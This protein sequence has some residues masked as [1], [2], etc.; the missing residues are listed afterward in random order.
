MTRPKTSI[1]DLSP[2][3]LT[4]IFLLCLPEDP[5]A[6]VSEPQPDL[7][8]APVLL[9]H[10][11]SSWRA[12]AFKIPRLW[13]QLRICLNFE[14]DKDA[15]TLFTR[16]PAALARQIEF[17]EW[18]V[19]KQHSV[20]PYL[21]IEVKH[22]PP[23]DRVDK[24]GKALPPPKE[25]VEFSPIKEKHLS[26]LL[27]YISSAQYLCVDD[28][29][30]TLM[31]EGRDRNEDDLP[32]TFPNLHTLWTEY[33]ETE[34]YE[35][36]QTAIATIHRGLFYL[37]FLNPI[38]EQNP[39]TLRRLYL[40]HAGLTQL[41]PN[42]FASWTVLTHIYLNIDHVYLTTWYA[43][44]RSLPLLTY[45]NFH[46]TNDILIGAFIGPPSETIL[47]RLISLLINVNT[48]KD[49]TLEMRNPVVSLLQNVRMPILKE[50]SLHM[51]R[52]SRW[53]SRHLIT[54]LYPI[55]WLTPQLTI[56]SL[57]HVVLPNTNPGISGANIEPIT[58]YTPLLTHVYITWHA[59]LPDGIFREAIDPQRFT[60]HFFFSHPWLDL[61]NKNNPVD[62]VTL[63]ISTIGMP[64]HLDP[65]EW[66]Q[67]KMKLLQRSMMTSV[68]RHEIP[69]VAFYIAI[70]FPHIAGM[71]LMS[72]Q[73]CFDV[74]HGSYVHVVHWKCE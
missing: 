66:E 17:L 69:N 70:D 49:V 56:L 16:T 12:L 63:N 60:E 3:T 4:K 9:C 72:E 15:N 67:A 55:L 58:R 32:M 71:E 11:D 8:V 30:S 53:E 7:T 61:S 34:P 20:P 44:L 46:I 54:E 1:T 27:D 62:E 41:D 22:Y 29:F 28:V 37:D 13:K 14:F 33:L 36:D 48:E 19:E 38:L 25:I 21:H 6:R 35:D 65:E 24:D 51:N 23:P 40:Y 64:D 57:G 73:V 52:E 74:Y 18:W 39:S 2:E 68:K 59:F 50:L 43:F 5:L 26:F 45:A 42:I 47:P 31:L 10:V